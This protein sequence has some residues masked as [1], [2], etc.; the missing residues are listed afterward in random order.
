M[1]LKY[2][3]TCRL[4]NVFSALCLGAYAS[5]TLSFVDNNNEA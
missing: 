5:N 1:F 3:C 4:N 2:I